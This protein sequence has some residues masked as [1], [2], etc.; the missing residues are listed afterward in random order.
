MSLYFKCTILRTQLLRISGLR[1]YFEIV[2]AENN[3]ARPTDPVTH[4]RD[5]FSLGTS[6]CHI[7]D[8]LPDS[9]PKIGTDD[10]NRHNY[11]AGS[12]RQKKHGISL[13]AMNIMEMDVKR[14]IPN[15][16]PFAPPELWDRQSTDGFAKVSPR[17]EI[18]NER[19]VCA[20]IGHRWSVMLLPSLPYCRKTPLS[21][22][23]SPCLPVAQ[24]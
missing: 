15:L 8:L 19:R 9:F 3:E 24:S 13:F 14:M 23:H 17:L 2:Q 10:L 1:P 5:L 20:H 11:G 16:Q 7:F 4:L 22:P 12:E 21:S 18:P 6:L